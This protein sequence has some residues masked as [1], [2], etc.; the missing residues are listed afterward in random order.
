MVTGVPI[1]IHF[2]QFRIPI[3]AHDPEIIQILQSASET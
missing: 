2:S 3:Q 1:S